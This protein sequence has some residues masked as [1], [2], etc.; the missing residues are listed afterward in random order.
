[1][2][3]SLLPVEGFTAQLDV[4]IK[5]EKIEMQ[6]IILFF[7]VKILFYS[8][9]NIDIKI[10]FRKVKLILVLLFI[11]STTLFAKDN[12]TRLSLGGGIYNFMEHGSEGLINLQLHIILSYFQEEKWQIL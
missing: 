8:P 12:K 10:M 9:I 6:L 2:L 3:N 7:I 5:I 1:M 11:P 4:R